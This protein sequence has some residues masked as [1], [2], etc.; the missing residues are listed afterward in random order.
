MKACQVA[1]IYSA[2]DAMVAFTS[3][4]FE[5]AKLPTLGGWFRRHQNRSGLDDPVMAPPDEADLSST[6]PATP[7]DSAGDAMP[8]TESFNP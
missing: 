3:E 6:E 4:S 5:K 2:D 7:D 8:P 1:R